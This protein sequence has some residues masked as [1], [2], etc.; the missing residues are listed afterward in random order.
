MKKALWLILGL[1][2]LGLGAVGAVLP[3]LPSF[4]FLLLAAFSFARSSDKMHAWFTGTALYKNNLESYVR[5]QGMTSRTKARIMVT[6]TA[7]MAFGFV[8]MLR[9]GLYI[10]CGILAAVWLA[11][12]IYFI[13]IV[14]SCEVTGSG[15]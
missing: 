4:P 2:S 8:T 14:K 6:V 9:R 12:L 5:G 11:H 1:A 15:R 3:V 10:P 7:L 13:F